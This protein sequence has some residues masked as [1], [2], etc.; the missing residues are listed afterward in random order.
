MSEILIGQNPE[1]P[2][3]TTT[4]PDTPEKKAKQIPEPSGFHVLCMVP[5]IE[6]KFDS[7]IVKAETT[8]FAEER[9]TTVLFVM[10]LG[11]D[12]YKDASRFPSGPWC[13]EGDFVLVRPNSGTRLLIHGQEF[14][15]IN[16]DTVEATVED[17][18]GIS[19]A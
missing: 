16:D 13:K 9:L 3:E 17:P 5:E 18:R 19:R 14:R 1:K 4:L 12:C 11:P 6:D 10:K 2:S 15:V 8:M 7:G